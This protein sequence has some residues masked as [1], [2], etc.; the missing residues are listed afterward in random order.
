MGSCD[1]QALKGPFYEQTLPW[2]ALPDAEL[3]FHCNVARVF[4]V[5]TVQKGRETSACI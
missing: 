4:A 5:G 1:N 3:R 2:I